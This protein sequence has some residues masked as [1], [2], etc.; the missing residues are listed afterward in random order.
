MNERTRTYIVALFCALGL[1]ACG[2]MGELEAGSSPDAAAAPDAAP[3]PD[4]ASG[5]WSFAHCIGDPDQPGMVTATCSYWTC[6][7]VPDGLNPNKIVCTSDVPDGTSS[8]PGTFTCV[9]ELS[10][11]DPRCP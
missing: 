3:T 8:G 11:Q 1:A 9:P 4:A 10:N 7:S 5:S 2:G 6:E